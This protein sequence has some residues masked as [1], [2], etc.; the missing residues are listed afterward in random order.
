M[1]RAPRIGFG[2]ANLGVGALV[3]WGVFRAL[4]TRWWLV[5]GAGAIVGGL[6]L[7]SGATLLARSKHAARVTRVA[8]GFSLA[9]GLAL[10]AALASSAAFLWGT[11][12]QVGRGGAAIF[13][14]VILLAV[15]YLVVLPAA[16][17]L[18]L[19][20]RTPAHDK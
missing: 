12:A 10:I 4:P 9:A 18:W 16:Q 11:Y 2:I 17:L 5:D 19:G 8:A 7:A 6:L 15:P 14:L 20:P 3:L 1:K 13:G